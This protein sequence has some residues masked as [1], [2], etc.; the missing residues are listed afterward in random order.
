MTMS[1]KH[2]SEAPISGLAFFAGLTVFSNFS[3]GYSKTAVIPLGD[4]PLACDISFRAHA[5]VKC[6]RSVPINVRIG[7]NR[8]E[9]SDN[10]RKKYYFRGWE[11]RSRIFAAVFEPFDRQKITCKKVPCRYTWLLTS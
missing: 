3:C 6:A 8:I 5:D 1:R 2:K 11:G 10:F 9:K 7:L 4:K